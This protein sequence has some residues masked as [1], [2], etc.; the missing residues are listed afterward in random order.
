VIIRYFDIVGSTLDEPETDAPLV[1]DSD[2]MLLFSVSAELVESIS[3]RN[4]KV[5]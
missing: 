2:G 5:I 4:P 1:V 3:W